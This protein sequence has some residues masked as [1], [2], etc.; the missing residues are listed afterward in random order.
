MVLRKEYKFLDDKIWD[1]V[2]K[3]QKIYP[4]FDANSDGEVSDEEVINSP[5]MNDVDDHLR[6]KVSMNK[7]I[8]GWSFIELDYVK[9]T[10]S[11]V[12]CKPQGDMIN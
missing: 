12:P 10:R 3:Q 9:D 6:N 5:E 11:E 4:M 1:D 7:Y 8:Y 2:G